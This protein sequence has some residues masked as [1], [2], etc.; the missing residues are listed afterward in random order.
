[1]RERR[2][3][4][5]LLLPRPGDLVKAGIFPCTFLLGVLSAGGASGKDVLRAALIWIALELLIY[6]ARYQ[7]NDIRGF[8]A[9]QRH[10]SRAARGRLPGPPSRGREHKRASALVALG[11]LAMLAILAVVLSSL[12]LAVPLLVLAVA[13]FAVAAL[14]EA[15]RAHATGRSD[16]I[17]PSVTGGILV[18]WAVIGAGYAIRSLAGFAAAVDLFDSPGLPLAALIAAWSFGISFVTGRWALEALAFAR[19]EQDG[20]IA[21]SV[22]PGQAREHS[23]ALIRW[24]PT[25]PQPA[26]EPGDRSLD[27]WRALSGGVSPFAPWEVAAVVAAAAAALT[28][29]LLSGPAGLPEAALFTIGGALCAT[30]VL[31]ARRL[32]RFA[33]LAGAAVLFALASIVDSPRPALTVL[34]WLAVLG[35]HLF[36]TAQSPS[37]LAHPLRSAFSRARSRLSRSPRGQVAMALPR[38]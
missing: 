19:R 35:A 20:G 5:Y 25:R 9:D 1:V 11:R 23:L 15:L 29:R 13:V 34:P 14:Y 12:D 38:R 4:S 22:E 31:S 36:F 32:R 30:A 7:W 8:E 17:P 33:L 18:I 21:W 16:R 10:P 27:G 26:E 24:L 3:W 2:L 37:T 28:G 6:Q